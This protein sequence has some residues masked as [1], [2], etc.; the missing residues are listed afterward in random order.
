MAQYHWD[1]DGYLAMIREEVPE[2]ERLQDE[3]A[4]A[5]EA[6]A[7]RVLEVGTGTG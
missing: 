6:D 2:Y 1:P 4:A 3:T 5:S 7:K